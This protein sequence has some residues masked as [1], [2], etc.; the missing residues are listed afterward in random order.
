VKVEQILALADEM[1][2]NSLSDSVKIGW[3]AD[4]EGRILTEIHKKMPEHTSLPKRSDDQLTLPEVYA[5][6]YLLYITAMIA[7]VEGDYSAFS[8]IN[9]EF[10][11]AL[12]AYAR[13]FI[14]N[15][16]EYLD[17]CN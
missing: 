10:E 13:W 11:S 7:F 12:A 3:I 17:K 16:S 14:R 4:V 9:A 1:K 6:V 15:R 5:R 2:S 8:R